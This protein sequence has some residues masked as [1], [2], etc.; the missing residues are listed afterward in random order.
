VYKYDIYYDIYMNSR[1]NTTGFIP[2]GT[3]Q[4]LNG[5]VAFTGADDLQS[6][7]IIAR[8]SGF[9]EGN[10]NRLIGCGLLPPGE[11]RTPRT[12]FGPELLPNTTYYFLV[13]TRLVVT[14]RSNG[15]A[16]ETK[17]SINTAILP[18]TT[19]LLGITPP[20]ESKRKPL[21]PTDFG[22]ATD[23]SGNQLVSGTSVTF[24]WLQ[25]EGDVIYQLIRT[26]GKVNPTADLPEYAND[27]EYVSFL[28]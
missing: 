12:V 15:Q 14:R 27:P 13:R 25:Q 19:I 16:V 6:T 8:V 2:I 4:D 7:S 20:D 17:N 23:N 18:V 1:T 9:T 22:I 10:T 26:T 21:A 11:T 5:D 24:R 28:N 3:T